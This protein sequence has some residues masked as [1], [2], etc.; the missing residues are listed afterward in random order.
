MFSDSWAE[1]FKGIKNLYD[2]WHEY[3]FGL[4]GNKAAKHF[5]SRER[6]KC[7]FMYSRRKVFWDMIQKMIN[8]GHTSDSA[9]DKVYLV[10]GRSLAFTYIL[11]KVV[12]DR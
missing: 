11:K 5:T 1:L 4:A 3:K 7:R 8:A 12:A 2:L 10:Y 6:G 9:V